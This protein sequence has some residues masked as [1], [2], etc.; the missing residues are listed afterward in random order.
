VKKTKEAKALW[1]QQSV[2]HQWTLIKNLPL[3]HRNYLSLSQISG[4]H[5][6]AYFSNIEAK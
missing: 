2:Q 4:R 1:Q 5:G 6:Q 3:I